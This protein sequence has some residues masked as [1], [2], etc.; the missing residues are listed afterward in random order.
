MRS[1]DT[2]WGRMVGAGGRREDGGEWKDGRKE[3]Q[4][5]S[6]TGTPKKILF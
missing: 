5:L 1:L 3:A 2:V 6:S 4:I